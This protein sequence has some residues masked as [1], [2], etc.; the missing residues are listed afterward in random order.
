MNAFIVAVDHTLASHQ[1]AE[2][3]AHLAASMHRPLHVVFGFGPRVCAVV[4]N[5]SDRYFVDTQSAAESALADLC[6]Q[7]QAITTITCSTVA[8]TP[9]VALGREA[10]RIDAS[11]VVLSQGIMGRVTARVRYVA[12]RPVQCPARPIVSAVTGR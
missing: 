7:L 10:K 4:S 1:R 12:R 5:G 2:S 8:A 3:A 9:S 11:P 6:H